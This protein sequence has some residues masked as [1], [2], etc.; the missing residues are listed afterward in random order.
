MERRGQKATKKE[1]IE[2]ESLV[3]DIRKTGNKATSKDER[4]ESKT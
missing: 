1:G 2:E 4:R 3:K